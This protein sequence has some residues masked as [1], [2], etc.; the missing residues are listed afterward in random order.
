[1]VKVFRPVAREALIW[2]L[3]A[4]G[5]RGR[6][7]GKG[8]EVAA[9][10]AVS[11]IWCGFGRR[12]SLVGRKRKEV[13]VGRL[14]GGRLFTSHVG[15]DATF[16]CE[17]LSSRDVLFFAAIES[18][19]EVFLTLKDAKVSLF[20]TGNALKLVLKKILSIE[21]LTSRGALAQLFCP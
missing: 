11:S 17:V 2:R 16:H 14:P 19:G 18:V 15:G 9:G 4:A 7:L 20:S 3:H 6:R 5:W 12:R 21:S 1:M 13:A 10:P 8:A